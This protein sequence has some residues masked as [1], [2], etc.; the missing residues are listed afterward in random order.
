MIHSTLGHLPLIK[1]L[2]KWKETSFGGQS[3]PVGGLIYYL[4]PPGNFT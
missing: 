2:G 1:L 4:T 3:Y